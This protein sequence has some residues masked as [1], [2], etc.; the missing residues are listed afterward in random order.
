LEGGFCYCTYGWGGTNCDTPITTIRENSGPIT[1]RV[2]RGSWKYYNFT[3]T[4]STIYI[5]TREKSTVGFAWLFASR[6]YAPDLRYHEYS[7][8]D[9]K[10]SYHSIEFKFDFPWEEGKPKVVI[11]GVYGSPFSSRPVE[12]DVVAW[13]TPF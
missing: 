7:D 1:D 13:G 11:I 9:T 8:V 12:Y 6:D 10:K 3:S 4:A 2:E 5:G